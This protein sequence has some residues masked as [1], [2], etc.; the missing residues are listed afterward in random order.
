MKIRGI[1]EAPAA[2]VIYRAHY[3]LETLCLD[4]DMLQLK[5][6]LKSSYANIVYEGKWFS[7]SRIALDAFFHETQKN[8]TGTVKLQ[9]YKGNIIFAGVTSPYSLH[10]LCLATFEEDATY[11][12]SDAT[13]FI[14][15][16]SLSA[17]VYGSVHNKKSE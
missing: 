13:G 12:H 6:S 3:I 7:Q 5:N 9:L 17:K 1:Y 14:R 4:R 16:F 8:I 11:N 10:S 15:I 2:A